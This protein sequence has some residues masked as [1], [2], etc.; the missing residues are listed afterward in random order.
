MSLFATWLDGGNTVWLDIIG[1]AASVS[2]LEAAVLGRGR[3]VGKYR[4][5]YWNVPPWLRPVLAVV[6]VVLLG[7]VVVHFLRTFHLRNQVDEKSPL[8]SLIFAG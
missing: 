6:G 7:L 1:L 4:V 8:H 3:T 2:L 5:R